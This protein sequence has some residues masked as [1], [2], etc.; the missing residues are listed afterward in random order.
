MSDHE[1]IELIV[2]MENPFFYSKKRSLGKLKNR[3]NNILNRINT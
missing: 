3:V 2:M 1:L